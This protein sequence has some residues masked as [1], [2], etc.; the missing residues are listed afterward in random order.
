MKANSAW[1]EFIGKLD[2]EVNAA[3]ELYGFAWDILNATPQQIYD[4]F[5]ATFAREL[6][7]VEKQ[8]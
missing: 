5:C 7:Q 1:Y 4:A 2:D 6:E 3:I 8:P